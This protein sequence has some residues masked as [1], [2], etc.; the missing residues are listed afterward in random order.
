MC[1]CV[2]R[3]GWEAGARTICVRFFAS[4]SN[5]AS[6]SIPRITCTAHT[7]RDVDVW[8]IEMD[9]CVI[10]LSLYICYGTSD[11]SP[12]LNRAESSGAY[13]LCCTRCVCLFFFGLMILFQFS[14][15]AAATFVVACV[16]SCV[17]DAH[18]FRHL[19]RT[20]DATAAAIIYVNGLFSYVALPFE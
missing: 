7:N 18:T 16:F 12:R 13:V 10:L 3:L 20:T 2:C 9:E 15:F 17:L 14:F 11:C 6:L 1:V 8:T 19:M 5:S 4:H